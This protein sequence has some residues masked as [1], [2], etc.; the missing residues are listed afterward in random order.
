MNTKVETLENNQVLLTVEVEANA[1]ELAVKDAYNH[2]KKD[3]SVPGFRK[4]K[5]PRHMIEKMY[6]PEVFY[7]KAADILIDNTLGNAIEENN[8]DIAARL[9][10]G[11]LQVVTL[12]KDG[13]TYTA[14]I[15]IKPEITLGEYK[16]LTVEVEKTSVND[17]EINLSLQQEAEKNARELTVTDRAVAPQDKV[18]IDFE[19]FV[20]GVA[21]EGGKGEDYDLVIGSRSF[22]DNFEDQLIGKNIGEEVDVNVT[23]PTEY[24]AASL[25]GK[26]ATFKVKIKGITV[27]EL[28][29]I[30]DDFAADVSEFETLEEYKSSIRTKLEAQ[31]EAQKKVE[32]E[33]KA[34]DQ[35]VENANFEVPEA[36]IEDQTDNNLRDFSNRMRQQGLELEQYLGFIGQDLAAFK[37]NF[38]KDATKQIKTRLVL[39]SIAKA[40]DFVVTE[41]EIDAEIN[42]IAEHYGMQQEQL[43]SSFVGHEKDMLIQ[44]IK[45]QKAVEMVTTSA[46]V[47]E[48]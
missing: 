36:M 1:V 28:P 16:N 20:D 13:M 22:I 21:F 33:N 48:K 17:E 8:I 46:K 10:E 5:V 11:E 47:I 18:T 23:F 38:K 7:N 27:K 44:D 24:H 40:E 34:I 41:E 25:A 43:K 32:I 2:M 26:P 3:F 30:D 45:L 12:T 35:A 9:R 4:G 14:Q 15:T 6:G 42:K 29:A 31:K 37:E 19:G 39:E